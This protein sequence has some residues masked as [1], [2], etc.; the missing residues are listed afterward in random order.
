MNSNTRLTSLLKMLAASLALLAVCITGKQLRDK[1]EDSFSGSD[2]DKYTI[3]DFAMGTSVSIDVYG[4]D[5]LT[6]Q[7]AEDIMASINELDTELISWRSED[8]ELYK[9]N[10]EY[11]PGEPYRMSE[12]L[13]EPL[14]QALQL[15]EDSD[16]ALDITIRPLANVWGIEDADDDYQLP[17][18]EEIRKAMSVIG[19][20][21]IHLNQ[22]NKL[23]ID[24]AG[25]LLD[26]GAVGKGYA[27]D[28]ARKLIENADVDG[29][30]VSVGGSVLVKGHKSD[31]SS[32]RVGIRNPKGSVNEMIGYLDFGTEANVCVST[33]GDYE[34]YVTVDGVMYHHILDRNIGAP[35]ESELSSV[36]VVCEN[37][38]VNDGLSTACYILG[39]EKSLPLLEQYDAEAVFIDRNNNVTITDGLEN[40]Y[41]DAR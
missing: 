1:K 6:K 13:S 16:G 23:T 10:N 8:S 15:C 25:M 27:L 33:S 14:K 30:I 17:D 35:A 37:G 28:K 38:L 19:Y 21:K 12:E 36:T 9:L 2:G 41:I 40:H 24:I 3:Y 11:K 39:Y 18:T 7:L 5:K 29:A 32:W 31:G 4:N 34:K 20:E 22:D 26:L